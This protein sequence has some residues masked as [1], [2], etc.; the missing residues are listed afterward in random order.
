[1]PLLA[2]SGSSHN[3]YTILY[4]FLEAQSGDHR[5]QAVHT[6]ISLRITLFLRTGTGTGY[7]FLP[8][9][10]PLFVAQQRVVVLRL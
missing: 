4:K 9:R 7:D 2:M 5:Q 3:L 8:K 6:G 10:E 1:M